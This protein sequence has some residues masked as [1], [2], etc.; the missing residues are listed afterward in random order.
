MKKKSLST[1]VYEDLK[2]QIL[3]NKLL[4][5]DKLIEMDIAH[6]LGVSRT[7]V[8]EA[9]AKLN[10]DG[11]AENFP[12]KSYIVSKISLKKA[13]ELYDVRTALEPLAVKFLAEEG[14]TKRNMELEDIATRLIVSIEDN[15]IPFAKKEI[16]RWN[17]ALIKLTKN[18]ILRDTL[19][20]VNER[21]YRFANFIFQSDDNIKDISKHIIEIYYAIEAKDTE[22]AFQISHEYVSGIFPMLESQSDYKTFRYF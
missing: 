22:K 10:A 1:I 20:I 4:P 9:L 16:T 17:N 7:P 12:R 6:D 15:D 5:G 18:T 2:M 19:Y 11:L 21:L 14:I 8:R 13:K 3:N